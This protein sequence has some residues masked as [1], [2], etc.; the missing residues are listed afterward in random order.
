MPP[1][2]GVEQERAG[3]WPFPAGKGGRMRPA[4]ERGGPAW[5]RLR[6]VDVASFLAVR[7]CGTVSGAARELGTSAAQVS[8]RI[9]RLEAQLGKRLLIRRAGG[10]AVSDEGLRAL[11]DL[12]E[13]VH[14]LRR[15]GRGAGA[16]RGEDRA[17]RE[18]AVAAPSPL[19]EA[20]LPSLAARD[21]RLRSIELPPAA[22]RAYAGRGLFD[23]A[24][25]WGEPGSF[26]ASWSVS[27]VGALRH[28]LFGPAALAERL[29]PRPVRP[30]L[31]RTL[32]FVQAGYCLNGE[33]V[34]T[35]DRCPLAAVDR[36]IL[37]GAG[38]LPLA[39]AL[40]ASTGSLLFAPA[41]AAQLL[42]PG[43]RLVEIPVAGWTIEDPVYL[44][45]NQDRMRACDH[46]R[47]RAI[48]S[49][50]VGAEGE[51]EG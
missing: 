27:R 3:Q 7:R 45:C 10:V 5:E 35:D 44:A 34:E 25:V 28:V 1:A 30:S 29:G 24:V 15:L 26:S 2:G 4:H 37:H 17:R 46:T 31:L 39:F 11:P 16:S 19:C 21:V 14:R 38:T 36:R 42:P 43:A 47:F 20:L 33:Y 32:P 8:K 40:A 49:A 41:L 12:E 51:G 50:A 23:A 6:F 22:I 48:L 9:T 13:I 18:I